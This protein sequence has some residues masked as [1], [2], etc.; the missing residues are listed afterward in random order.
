V[1]GNASVIGVIVAVAVILALIVV[2]LWLRSRSERLRKRFGPEYSRAIAETGNRWKAESA[3]HGRE[4]R[5]ES[6]H[7]RPLSSEERAQ[8]Q[9]S[10]RSIQ[11]QFIDDPNGT[12]VEADRLIRNV[13]SAEGYPVADFEQ[14]AADISVDHPTVVE[15]YR[16]GH[17]IALRHAEGRANTEELRQAMVHYRT[18]FED[19]L[20]QA[21][22]TQT[23]RVL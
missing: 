22:Y 3:L 16:G 17:S 11:A 7:I 15:N 14:R 20:G 19:M 10:W 6:L 4:K 2:W 1:Q 23:G 18:L 8:F 21:E 5:V 12:L 13:L 9:D